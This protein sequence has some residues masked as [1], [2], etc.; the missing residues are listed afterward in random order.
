MALCGFPPAEISTSLL[1]GRTGHM[2]VEK[3]VYA[4]VS[5]TRGWKSTT[6]L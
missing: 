5:R 3:P 6:L 2:A 1:L 4:L